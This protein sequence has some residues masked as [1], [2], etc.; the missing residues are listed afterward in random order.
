M[1]EPLNGER[2]VA[3]ALALADR[4]GVESLSMRKIARELGVQAMSL[5]NHV[6]NKEE[7]LDELVEHI[8]AEIEVPS[9]EDDWKIAMR[10]R[11]ISA[12]EMLLRHPWAIMTMMTRANAGPAMLRYVNATLG[13]LRE[14]GFSY[15]LADHIWHAMDNHIYGFTLQEVNFPFEEADYAD[16]A[17]EFMPSFASDEFPYFT[18]LATLIME[19]KHS[20]IHDFTFGLDLILDGLERYLGNES[21]RRG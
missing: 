12:H 9:L 1:R 2:I 17:K 3:A 13:S 15:E 21:Q 16:A 14:A 5:Y 20:G 4:E 6:A 11:G 19:K 18:E 7:I 10:K 8:V